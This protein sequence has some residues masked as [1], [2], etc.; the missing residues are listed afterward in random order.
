MAEVTVY[1]IQFLVNNPYGTYVAGDK[2]D[3]RVETTELTVNLDGFNII[4]T[5]GVHTYLNGIQ[6]YSGPQVVFANSIVSLEYFKPNICIGTSLFV[7]A[8]NPYSQ[9]PYLT[10][11]TE[12]NS[13]SCSITPITCD[14]IVVGTPIVTPTSDDVTS[15]GEITINATSSAAIQY[16][17]GSD[18][19]YGSG[20][21]GGTFSGLAFGF[22]RVYIRDAKNCAANVYVE[23]PVTDTYGVLYQNNYFDKLTGLATK[24]EILER[25]YAGSPIEYKSGGVPILVTMRGEGQGKFTGLLPVQADISLISETNQQYI[26][27]YTNDPDK[28]RVKYYKETGTETLLMEDSGDILMEN[29]GSL[30]T[31][32]LAGLNLKYYGKLLPFL[33]Q[34]DYAATP[35]EIKVTASDGL[36]EL[37]DFSFLQKDGL[38]FQG[39]MSLIKIIAY[40]L[41]Y[42]KLDL[43]IRVA[44]N[45]YAD[46]MDITADDD[47]LDQAYLDVECFYLQDKDAKLSDILFAILKP[48]GARMVQWDGYWNIVRVEEM[49]ALY[50]YREFDKDG[51]YVSNGAFDPVLN[52]DYP[53]GVGDV[54]FA[55]IPNLELQ[56]GY[57]RIMVTYNLGLDD[58]ILK[59]GDFE[60]VTRY[61]TTSDDYV[62]VLNKQGWAFVNGNYPLQEGYEVIEDNNA[63]WAFY[64][65]DTTI[66]GLGNAY[67]LSDSYPI[68]MG[69]GN[70]LKISLRC[71]VDAP[72]Q[73]PPRYIAIRMMVKY[74]DLYLVGD[75]TWV[76]TENILTFFANKLNQYD[77]YEVV[78]QQPDSGTPLDGMDLTVRVYHAHAYYTDFNSTTTLREFDTENLPEGYR[79]TYKDPTATASSGEYVYYYDLLV[80]TDPE[81]G[82]T[83]IAPD[84]Y[85]AGNGFKKWVLVDYLA[86]NDPQANFAIDFVKMQF[87]Y[88]GADPIKEIVRTATAE[89]RNKLELKEELIIGSSAEF[90][91]TEGNIYFDYGRILYGEQPRVSLIR[92]NVL[93]Y[94]LVY[95]GWL[96]DSTGL[97]AWNDW[98]R[99]DVNES[100]QLHNIFLKSNVNQYKRSWRLLRGSFVSKTSLI[101][102]LNSFKEVN[103]S[104]RLYVPVSLSLDDKM[105]TASYEILEIIPNEGGS[106]GSGVADFSSEFT[107][108]FGSDFN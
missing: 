38:R 58:N 14:L 50:D 1:R 86:I 42:T 60:L 75:G 71:K 13:P 48:F 15:D 101:G 72:N 31:E 100:E 65:P 8:N 53:N 4:H 77:T 30:L 91:T 16:N 18:F 73:F 40:C 83:L 27:L 3:V 97:I 67:I 37:K 20:Q 96:K 63:A 36:A 47:P 59:N 70:R 32:S 108:E 69:V 78:A 24:I 56:N 22:Y 62:P 103:D 54:L 92:T 5:P 57:G 90:I 45:L 76:A 7:P 104:N 29:S 80:N 87:Q 21:V 33:Y 49:A 107:N 25:G 79:V 89:P 105:N 9:F 11:A 81:S 19:L 84:D 12:A 55:G 34:E 68:K 82:L 23:V 99:D 93:S 26:D 88:N 61:E 41:S 17:L 44:C 98:K 43:P 106:D 64:N 66:Q 94:D 51:N 2:L 35:Y 46:G 28:Y 74:G 102:M 10:Y 52:V 85:G 6:I 95:K 39:S